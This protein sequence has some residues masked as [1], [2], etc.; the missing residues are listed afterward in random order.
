MVFKP[1]RLKLIN[2]FLPYAKTFE[3]YVKYFSTLKFDEV[4]GA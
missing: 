2:S 1:K 4:Q 3:F